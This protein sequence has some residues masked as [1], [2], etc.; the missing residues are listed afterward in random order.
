MI[1]IMSGGRGR[2]GGGGGRYLRRQ[3]RSRR[4]RP[5]PHGD[6]DKNLSESNDAASGWRLTI[7]ILVVI[8][9]LSFRVNCCFFQVSN[10][11]PVTAF[12][13]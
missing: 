13:S 1:Y 3:Y 9:F 5:G 11:L 6:G 2:G 7:L 10:F 12:T 4:G 8:Y